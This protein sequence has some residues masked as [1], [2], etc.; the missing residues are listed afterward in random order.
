VIHIDSSPAHAAVGSVVRFDGG[1]EGDG[2]PRVARAGAAQPVGRPGVSRGI[3]SHS[4]RGGPR[5]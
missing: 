5:A 3:H 2:A 1:R 4:S